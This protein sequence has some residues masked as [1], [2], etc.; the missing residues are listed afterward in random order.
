MVILRM[1]KIGT[2]VIPLEHWL[3]YNHTHVIKNKIHDLSLHRVS[4]GMND[5]YLSAGG[6]DYGGCANCINQYT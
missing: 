3:Y 4:G 5:K 6:Q 2:I 1:H